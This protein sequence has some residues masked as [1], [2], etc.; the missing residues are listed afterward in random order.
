[1]TMD[2]LSQQIGVINARIS[3]LNDQRNRNIGMKENI[4]KQIAVSIA[5]YKVKYGIDL[6]SDESVKAEYQRVFNEKSQE[7]E[8]M[9]QVLGKIESGDYAGAN[10]LLGVQPK[11]EVQSE[12][13]G[14]SPNVAQPVVTAVQPASPVA[15]QVVQ[16][17]ENITKPDAQVGVQT[18]PIVQQ[19]VAQPAPPIIQP[20]E[21]V[22]S[23]PVP[24]TPPTMNLT[25]A[26]SFLEGFEKP[27]A[28]PTMAQPSVVQPTTPPPTSPLSFDSI[29]G[30]TQFQV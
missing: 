16:P 19:S 24:P 15:Q 30:G 8:K 5:D 12:Q 14:V 9:E 26:E 28:P 27:P 17:T 6:T 11:A 23:A 20:T 18:Q 22:M 1:M 4:E 13:I 2:E 21:P 3:K 7:V 29:L 10:E 25:G